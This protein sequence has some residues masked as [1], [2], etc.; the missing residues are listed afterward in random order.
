VEANEGPI[1]A[2]AVSPDGELVAS[3][4]GLTRGSVA[5]WSARDGTLLW[6]RERH[7]DGVFGLAFSPDGRRLASSSY[8]AVVRLWDVRTGEHMLA[9]R[10]DHQGRVFAVQF[11]PDGSRLVSASFDGRLQI[12][13]APRGPG[14]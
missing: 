5:L 1:R 3:G 7:Y 11:S 12:R 2:I 10:H 6:R 8:D 4:D 14:R 13:S 9:M